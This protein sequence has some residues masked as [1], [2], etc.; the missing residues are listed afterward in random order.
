MPE[1]FGLQYVGADGERHTPVMLHRACYGSLERFMGI[2][3]ENYAGAFP[4]CAAAAHRD[5]REREVH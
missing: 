4:L 3:I 5:P 1:R 2:I